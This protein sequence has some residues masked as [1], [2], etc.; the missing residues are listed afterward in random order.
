M[1]NLHLI[2]DSSSPSFIL[3]KN[4]YWELNICKKND[5]VDFDFNLITFF[6][7]SSSRV[8]VTYFKRK[9]KIKSMGW[10][11]EE[12]SCYFIAIFGLNYIIIGSSQWCITKRTSN[13]CYMATFEWCANVNFGQDTWNTSKEYWKKDETQKKRLYRCTNKVQQTGR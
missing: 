5:L 1:L 6:W 10:R 12:F 3:A 8:K 4:Y 9:R 11:K 13:Y 7:K 2:G